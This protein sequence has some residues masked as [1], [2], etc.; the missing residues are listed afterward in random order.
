MRGDI[1]GSVK[2]VFF[3]LDNT[4]ISRDASFRE[5][6]PLWFAQFVPDMPETDYGVQITQIMLR[7]QNGFANRDE[8]GSWVKR[9]YSLNTISAKQV[10]SDFAA[11]IA[12]NIKRNE[13]MIDFVLSLRDRYTLGVISNGSGRT[14]RLKLA[15]AGLEDAFDADKIYIEGETGI[16]KPDLAMF[17][18]PCQQHH[19]SPGEMLFIGDHPIDDIG[20][21]SHA[22]MKTCWIRRGKSLWD[23]TCSPD[24]TITSMEELFHQPH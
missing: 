13:E 17:L 3:D 10:I 23:L 9:Q 24:V 12:G 19:I 4:L 7:D 6:L 18:L 8:F 14:Q 1:F 5:I 16:A 11:A 15:N 21:A 2:A 22:G 20:G